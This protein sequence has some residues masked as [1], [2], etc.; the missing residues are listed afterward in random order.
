MKR[1]VCLILSAAGLGFPAASR[2]GMTDTTVH[3][4]FGGRARDYI[5]SQPSSCT[6]A[7]PVVFD[8]HGFAGS[9][10]TQLADSGHHETGDEYGYIVVYPNGLH[11]SWNAG[12]SAYG[13]CCGYA[14][15]HDIDDVRFLI[16]VAR[17]VAAAYPVDTGRI[18]LSGWSN[19][20]AMA[21]R[22][23]IT[24]PDVFAAEACTS[25]YLLTTQARTRRPVA[26][27]EFHGLD[28]TTVPYAQTK[29]WT[30]VA[31]NFARWA[32]LDGCQ[33][34]PVRTFLTADSY[35]DR[36][37]DCAAGVTVTQYTLAHTGHDTYANDQ[38]ID[39]AEQMWFGLRDYRLP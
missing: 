23:Q 1:L 24:A 16:E 11:H 30:G 31:N 10:H 21:Q 19:G 32:A 2:A 29:S 8:L 37:L 33:G 18:Y 17:R 12:H 38:G 27:T 22:A 6:A 4:D 28:D 34:A 15:N 9:M 7:C 26:V 3:F 25:L 39:V 14:E 35:Y 5:V 36:Y 13:S 20:C